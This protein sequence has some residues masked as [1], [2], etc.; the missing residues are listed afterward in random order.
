MTFKESINLHN[1]RSCC[2]QRLVRDKVGDR[3]IIHVLVFKYINNL[4][5]I[6]CEKWVSN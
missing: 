2:K 6:Y 4:L 3:V 1:G 5:T